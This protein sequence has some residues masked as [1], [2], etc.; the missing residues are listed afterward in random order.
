M[1]PGFCRRGCILPVNAL[2]VRGSRGSAESCW[3]MSGSL[4][5]QS[6]QGVRPER[7]RLTL[8]GQPL[9]TPRPCPIQ[10]GTGGFRGCALTADT[11]RGGRWALHTCGFC[12]HG[13]N[14]QMENRVGSRKS[15][16]AKLEL[17]TQGDNLHSVCTV[18]TAVSVTF[19]SYQLL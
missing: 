14:Q 2:P 6:V 16:K 9:S 7:A 19:T 10:S 5:S 12:L 13:S 1:R 3:R 11:P 4:S 8:G 18:F 17:I 15:A